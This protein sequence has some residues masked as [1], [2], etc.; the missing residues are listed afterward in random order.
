MTCTVAD[1]NSIQKV[2]S[3]L[4]TLTKCHHVSCQQNVAICASGSAPWF[5]ED[6]GSAGENGSSIFHAAVA[7]KLQLNIISY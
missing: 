6:V 3:F 4:E 1:L 5:L 2:S 7:K